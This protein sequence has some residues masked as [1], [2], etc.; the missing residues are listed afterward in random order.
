V[1]FVRFGLADL[2]AT[3]KMP[4]NQPE[5][6]RLWFEEKP[7]RTSVSCIRVACCV[8]VVV[9]RRGKEEETSALRLP[10]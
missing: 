1:R 8:V 4:R 9:E 10:M 7:G 3:K 5:V 6:N 2:K